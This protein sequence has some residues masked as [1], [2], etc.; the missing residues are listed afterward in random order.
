MYCFKML[1]F[2]SQILPKK[3]KQLSQISL[4]SGENKETHEV[5]VNNEEKIH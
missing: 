5:N 2:F 3:L 4:E 1:L